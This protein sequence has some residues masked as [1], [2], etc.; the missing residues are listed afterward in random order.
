SS[1]LLTDL[2]GPTANMYRMRGKNPEVCSACRRTS[3]LF[4]SVC[5]NLDTSHKPLLDLYE[6]VRAL[7]GIKKATIGSGI[8]YDLFLSKKGFLDRDGKRYFETLLQYHVSGRLKVAPEHT[9]D[10]VL[11]R[12]H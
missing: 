3:C 6:A 9:Q 2:G 7:P 4:P 11:A 8:R 1:D 10:N 5:R 12:M